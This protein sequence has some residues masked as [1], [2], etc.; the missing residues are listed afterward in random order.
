MNKIFKIYKITSPVPTAVARV[1]KEIL[2]ILKILF[3]LSNSL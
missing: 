2:L 3:I 1:R